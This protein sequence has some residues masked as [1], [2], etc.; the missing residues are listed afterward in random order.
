MD[1]LANITAQRHQIDSQRSTIAAQS[2][3]VVALERRQE[4]TETILQALMGGIATMVADQRTRATL[5]TELHTN[6]TR[7]AAAV[8]SAVRTL[9]AA[10]TAQNRNISVLNANLTSLVA[11]IRRG[12]LGGGGGGGDATEEGDE[13]NSG[14][15]S[16]V[17]GDVRLQGQDSFE[18][19]SKMRAI[20]SVCKH[21]PHHHQCCVPP[22]DR[23]TLPPARKHAHT[24][25]SRH[26]PTK[27][28][29]LRF[30]PRH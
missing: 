16:S 22:K 30:P 25:T 26:V 7:D 14:W 10:E 12:G 29:P 4:S 6:S 18:V 3:A 8:A 27:H 23:P 24:C 11:L 13:L 19:L 17:E 2:T 15:G 28:P 1:L 20:S 5:L 9:V 21:H